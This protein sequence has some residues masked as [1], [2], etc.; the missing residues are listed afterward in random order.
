M[1][2][3]ASYKITFTNEQIFALVWPLIADQL[4][5]IAVG[6]ADSLMVAQVGDAAISAVSLVDAISALMIMLFSAMAVG[7]SAVAGQYIGRREHENARQSCQHLVIL[8][9]LVSAAITGLLYIFK[10]FILHTIYGQIAPDIMAATD[11]YYSIVMASIPGIALYNA[12]AAI[13][14]SMKKTDIALKVSLLMNIINVAGNALLIFVFHMDVAGVAIPTLVSRTVAGVL[15]TAMLFNE[16][17]SLNL[18]GITHFRLR[19]ELMKNIFYISVPSGIENGTFHFGRLIIFSLVST[20]GTASIVANAIG[21]TMGNF[22]LC[23]GVGVNLGIVTLVSQCVGAG[24]YTAARAY[25]GKM[26]RLT[27]VSQLILNIALALLMPFILDVYGVS[28]EARRLAMSVVLLHG[29]ASATTW[30]P[31]FQIPSILRAAGDAR[32]TMYV[33][34]LTMWLGRILSAFIFVKVF[35]LGLVSIW[36]AHAIIDWIARTVIFT[37]RYR[38]NAWQTKAIK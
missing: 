5:A 9:I 28:D 14:R 22:H 31:A 34:M 16:D 25:A 36:F 6:M 29:A 24:D 38:G 21:N 26:I 15:I 3:E 2:D 20:L 37:W 32:F 30:I 12:G 27:F 17:L 11:K 33:S 23:I 7:G 8:M 10:Y 4:L 13:F 19:P 18:C 1:N 35:H